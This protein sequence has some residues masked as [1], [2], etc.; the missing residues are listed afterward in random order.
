MIAF[1]AEDNIETKR[2][3]YIFGKNYMLFLF[4][5]L[6]FFG[7][8]LFFEIIVKNSHF[9]LPLSLCRDGILTKF[10]IS[11]SPIHLSLFQKSQTPL[12]LTFFASATVLKKN[13]KKRTQLIKIKDIDLWSYQGRGY[14]NFFKG[15]IGSI[16]PMQ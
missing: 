13:V 2:Y 10:C 14:C 11:F 7:T 5:V 3:N 1:C 12:N 9:Y 4:N 8:F 15:R 16:L 6:C